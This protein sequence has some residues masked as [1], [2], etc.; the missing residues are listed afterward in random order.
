MV[1]ISSSGMMTGGRILHHLTRRLG[2]PE[3]LILLSGYQAQGTRGRSL[4]EGAKT[5]RIH[6]GNWPIECRHE[7]I[8]GLSSHADRDELTR[9]VDTAPTPP[10]EVFVVHGEPDSA[11]SFA[12]HLRGRMGAA[13]HV[14]ALGEGFE[15]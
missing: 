14:P 8:H 4:Q 1:I 5:L 7:T 11:R 6:G 9:W 2:R 12:A 3:N 15:I 13:V 10:G